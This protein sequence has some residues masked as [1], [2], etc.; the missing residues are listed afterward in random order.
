VVGTSA[1]GGDE[2]GRS[3]SG[4]SQP[5]PTEVPAMVTVRRPGRRPTEIRPGPRIWWAVALLAGLAFWA[6][7]VA[8]VGPRLAGLIDALRRALWGGWHP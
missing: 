1:G 7:V 3:H 5:V 8:L 6:G 4:H 2:L